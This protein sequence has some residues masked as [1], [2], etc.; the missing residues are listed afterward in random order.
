MATITVP[1]ISLSLGLGISRPLA[2]VS[3]IAIS[4]ISWE[5]ISVEA[6]ITVPG[7]SLSLGLGISRPL[8]IVSTIAIASIGWKAVAVEATISV[9]W[10]SLCLCC[11]LGKRHAHKRQNCNECLHFACLLLK[12]L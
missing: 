10:S 12:M 4:A 7:I 9:P 8:A 1:G 2:I 5:A 3:T 11:R 6:T